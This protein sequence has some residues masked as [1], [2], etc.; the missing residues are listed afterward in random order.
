VALADVELLKADA[1]KKPAAEKKLVASREALTK[2]TAEVDVVSEKYTPLKGAQ[3]SIESPTESADSLNR[4]FPSTSTGRRTALARWI[5]ARDNPL[6]AR[7]AVNH[8]WSRHFQTPLVPTV[9]DF[10]R[11]GKPPTNPELLD[12]LAV[13]L[14]ENGWSMKHLHRLMVTSNSYRMASTTA[15]A[16]ANLQRDPENR[17]LWRMN[18]GR[19]EAQAVR[20]SLL[21]LAG[22]LDSTLGGPSIPAKEDSKRR[23]LY[24]VHSHNEHQRFL[25]VFDDAGVQECYRREQ[26]IMP[27]Q[28]LALSNSKA[29]LDAAAK[30]A[31]RL[32]ALSELQEDDAFIKAAFVTVLAA[33]P[34]DDELT[35]CRAA[36]ADWAAILPAGKKSASAGESAQRQG[37]INLVHALLNHNDFITIR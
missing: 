30:I 5:T 27:Q 3:K 9:F 11:K 37:R 21:H 34:T 25:S 10:G 23:S 6:A 32:L 16:E 15:N 1:A 19:L 26:N 29:A 13:E 24:F 18:S 28:A 8:L 12:W 2:A 17:A 20:D 7:V 14:L 31:D 33:S 35:A 4:P 36:L 22:D